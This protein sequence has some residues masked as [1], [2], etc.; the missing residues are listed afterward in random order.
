MRIRHPATLKYVSTDSVTVA[1]EI[2]PVITS[3]A[4]EAQVE[5]TGLAATLREAGGLRTAT[6][7]LTGAQPWLDTLSSKD[8][9]LTCD[10]GSLAEPGTYVLPLTCE[11]ENSEGQSYTCEINPASVVVT[12]IHR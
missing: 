7:F 11:V 3:R 10:L 5:M 12:V 9:K 6:V 2:G 4:Y 1:V 8:V